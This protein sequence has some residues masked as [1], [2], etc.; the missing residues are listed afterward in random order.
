MN[1]IRPL[2][3]ARALAASALGTLA[4]LAFFSW[5]WSPSVG[6]V[7]GGLSSAL[8]VISVFAYREGQKDELALLE[9]LRLRVSQQ[10]PVLRLALAL[11]QP[12]RSIAL[13]LP[14]PALTTRFDGRSLYEPGQLP[15]PALD[16]AHRWVDEWELAARDDLGEPAPPEGFEPLA[17]MLLGTAPDTLQPWT[18]D[19][20]AHLCWRLNLLLCAMETGALSAEAGHALL[21]PAVLALQ[22]HHA[23]WASYAADLKQQRWDFVRRNA[24]G[25]A[26]LGVQFKDL[27][28]KP[29]SPWALTPLKL[30][31]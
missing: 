16:H 1:T 17:R 11:A 7:V 22:S 18:P 21:A 14:I 8:W 24:W 20:S 10:D 15:P 3:P 19:M 31:L 2:S 13:A 27:F 12:I 26:A 30:P 5:L 29:S 9:R 23:D 6:L 28:G 25:V 4:A